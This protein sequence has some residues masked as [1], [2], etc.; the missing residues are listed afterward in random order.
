MLYDEQ[1]TDCKSQAGWRERKFLSAVKSHQKIAKAAGFLE[2]FG[3]CNV[4]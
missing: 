2:E 3:G 1:A 4:Y